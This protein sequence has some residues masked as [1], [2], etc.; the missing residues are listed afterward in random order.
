MQPGLAAG[1]TPAAVTRHRAMQSTRQELPAPKALRPAGRRRGGSCCA[2]AVTA[3]R[4]RRCKLR[5]S[6]A[7]RHYFRRQRLAE[8]V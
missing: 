4:R 7:V 6:F 3:A 8:R 5:M 2:D 1:A